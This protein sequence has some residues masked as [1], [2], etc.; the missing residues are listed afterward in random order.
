MPNR[1]VAAV[2]PSGASGRTRSASPAPYATGSAPSCPQELE[3]ALRGGPDHGGAGERRELHDEHA[4]SAR[5]A[6][7]QDGVAGPQVDRLQSGGRGEAGY[8]KR[9]RHLV[10]DA[11]RRMKERLGR[12]GRRLDHHEVGGGPPSAPP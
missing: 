3:G 2:T 8:G 4:D 7:D 10:A 1:S 6:A 11:I 12:L 9:A 5:G